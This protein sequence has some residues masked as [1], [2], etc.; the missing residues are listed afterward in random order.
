MSKSLSIEKRTIRVMMN[1]Y[2]RKNH[3]T[4]NLCS[5]CS[6]LLAYAYKRIDHCPFKLDKPACNNCTVHCYAKEKRE[7]IKEVMRFAGPRMP[8]RHP[9]LSMIHLLK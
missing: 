5:E 6:D 7:R 9:F 1:I 2:C 3:G 4:K 8:L